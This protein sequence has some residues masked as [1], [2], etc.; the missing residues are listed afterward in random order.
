M[1]SR[2]Q[3]LRSGVL[4]LSLLAVTAL[5]TVWVGR[6]INPRYEVTATAV[7]LPG[8]GTYSGQEVYGSTHHTNQVLSVVLD[9]ATTRDRIAELHLAPDYQVVAEERRTFLEV[10]VQARTADVG[11][12]TVQAVLDIGKEELEERQVLAGTPPDARYALSV[13]RPPAVSDTVPWRTRNMSLVAL[14]GTI[15][16]VML[17]REAGRWSARAK[18]RAPGRH[19]GDDEPSGSS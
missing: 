8:E 10:S 9:S 14:V 17:T 3:L 5:A 18:A 11:L 12:Q 19:R 16:S 15:L 7:V 1:S 2:G 6:G 13:L 4:L